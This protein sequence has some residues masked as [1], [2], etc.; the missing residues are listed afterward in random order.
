V[1]DITLPG[2]KGNEPIGFLAA[3]GLLRVCC[4]RP[5]LGS[6]KL[7]WEAEGGRAALLVTE[8]DCDSD[9]LIDELL[10]HMR[11][12]HTWPSFSGRAPDGSVVGSDDWDDIKV[13]PRLF[14]DLLCVTRPYAWKDRQAADFLSAL[15]SEVV[16]A[17]NSD[18]L[19][20]SALHMTSGQQKFLET[21]RSLA[22]SLDPSRRQ[23]RGIQGA[24]DAFREALFEDWQYRD[25]FSSLGYDPITEAIYSLTAAAPTDTGPRSTRAAVWLAVEALPLFPCFPVARRL[26][27]RGFDQTA[28]RFRWPAWKQPVGLPAVRTL[29]GLQDLYATKLEPARLRAY[30][31]TAV[32]GCDRVTIGKGYGQLRPGR[33]LC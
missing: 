5:G 18:L 4:T 3:L 27:T 7:G 2:L 29:L 20:P 25:A 30:G 9:R 10:A 16:S 31:I 12:R 23:A 15:G 14:A 22:A 32:F 19:K 1:S 26:H 13:E 8:S 33:R 24:G 21:I 11:D 28:S 6:P 17:Q